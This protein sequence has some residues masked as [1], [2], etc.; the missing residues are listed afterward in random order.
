MAETVDAQKTPDLTAEIKAN[1]P[2]D[3]FPPTPKSNTEERPQPS[4]SSAQ[5]PPET[6]TFPDTDAA[7]NTLVWL[8]P[9]QY[10]AIRDK[11]QDQ[12]VWSPTAFASDLPVNQTSFIS[13]N[14]RG[15]AESAA[16]KPP[17]AQ[18][19]TAPVVVAGQIGDGEVKTLGDVAEL[20]PT[21]EEG[22][23]GDPDRKKVAKGKANESSS[24][25][26]KGVR[27]E[28]DSKGKEPQSSLDKNTAAPSTS[29]QQP[30]TVGQ[31]S[32]STK[33]QSAA[34]SRWA[35]RRPA[36]MKHWHSF[37]L[38]KNSNSRSRRNSSTSQT[39]NHNAS[40][41]NSG[42]N[43]NN[44]NNSTEHVPSIPSRRSPAHGNPG[45]RTNGNGRIPV[46]VPHPKSYEKDADGKLK[47]EDASDPQRSRSGQSNVKSKTR[48][49]GRKRVS[50]EPL[51]LPT[52]VAAGT[53]P[54][55]AR[56]AA[57]ASSGSQ[58]AQQG[59]EQAVHEAVS[60]QI[61]ASG[62]P[63]AREGNIIVAEMPEDSTKTPRR[64]LVLPAQAATSLQSK[65]T[66][67]DMQSSANLQMPRHTNSR[68]RRARHSSTRRA[69][70]V[71]T[72]TS[73]ANMHTTNGQAQLS[74]STANVPENS[75]VVSRGENRRSRQPKTTTHMLP[76]HSDNS[77]VIS[78]NGIMPTTPSARSNPTTA[79]S[80]QKTS[81]SQLVVNL[82]MNL[83]LEVHLKAKLQG[84]LT[85]T[86]FD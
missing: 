69:A 49:G 61:A 1:S 10:S 23:D 4:S 71:S 37:H 19:E 63:A 42:N 39:S 12:F 54:A 66:E 67:A 48:R 24:G 18:A 43:S 9:S 53:S 35:R 21:T 70:H 41:N 40:E 64:P 86:L 45:A 81:S 83:E 68:S 72:E 52:L 26:E 32:G 77:I 22:D 57:N 29:P 73:V 84:D 6:A 78:K 34:Q 27:A 50:A 60:K 55:S 80:T 59:A 56:S 74:E 5:P 36:K 75:L 25:E 28:G 38:M 85:L 13:V 31:P 58:A 51:L 47:V 30:P 8:P 15:R 16:S 33:P 14:S 11:W 65:K 76:A 3:Q 79:V 82:N 2:T 62:R 46:L 20:G 44:N 7:G 17:F